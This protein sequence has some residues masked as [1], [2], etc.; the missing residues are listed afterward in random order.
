MAEREPAFARM[1]LRIRELTGLG[2][3]VRG[4]LASDE[5]RVGF[6][7]QPCDPKYC[8]TDQTWT[9]H[10]GRAWEMTANNAR[11]LAAMSVMPS[12]GWVRFVELC[13]T[14]LREALDDCLRM[15]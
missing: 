15:K 13:R 3:E 6:M 7:V 11:R 1:D 4:V 2:S 8:K 5:A 12:L 10:P 14:L 9:E